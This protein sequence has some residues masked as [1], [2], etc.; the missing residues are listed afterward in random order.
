MLSIIL[1]KVSEHDRVLEE[2]KE[3]IKLMKQIIGSHSRSIQLL[4]NLTGHVM[5]HL[6]PTQSRGCQNES[7]IHLA[8]TSCLGCIIE[9]TR[10]NL[11][12]IIASEIHMHAKKSHASLP[13]LI[14]ITASCKRARVPRDAKK[15]VELVATASTI[16][17]KIKVEYLKDQAKKRQKEVVATVSIP[18]EASLLILAPGSSGISDSIT[19]PA[20]PLGPSTVARSPRPITVAAISRPPL[21]L[22]SLL[23]IEQLA[24]SADRQ[25][26]SPETS[27]PGMIQIALTDAVTPLST[28]I[29]ALAA[30]I[31]VCEHNQGPIEEVTTLKA[32]IAEL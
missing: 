29:D 9:K 3:N 10:I 32:A 28:T 22:T 2:V 6:H 14:L 16:I 23:R 27:V 11:G 31:A 24:L 4:E 20:N 19:T 12:M 18:A 1:D 15:D 8:K 13:F 21:T 7:I 17:Y 5:P 26:A 30:R 25:A